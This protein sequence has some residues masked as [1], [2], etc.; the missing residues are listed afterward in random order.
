M[1]GMW[2]RVFEYFANSEENTLVLWYDDKAR[3]VEMRAEVRE[4]PFGGMEG[5]KKRDEK[6][7][8]EEIRASRI[9]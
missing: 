7:L 8:L 6:T 9:D 5:K 3:A 4:R 2:C 1:N